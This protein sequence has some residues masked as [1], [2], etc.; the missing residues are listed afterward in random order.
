MSVAISAGKSCE[1]AIDENPQEIKMGA[2]QSK[3][4]TADQLGAPMKSSAFMSGCG[5]PDSSNAEICAAVK[6]GKPLGV[7]V[8]VSP[9][10]NK[11][12]ATDAFKKAS[13]YNVVFTESVPDLKDFYNNPQY[14]E[15]LNP[16][17][18]TLNEVFAG[19]KQAKPALD[20]IAA[21]HQKVLDEAAKAK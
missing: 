10:N 14:S 4:L 9:A 21:A 13:P 1:K 11:V 18:K 19:S 8:K 20:E 5:L 7:S 3:D 6:Q 17:Q 16:M 12:A 15:L 2:K